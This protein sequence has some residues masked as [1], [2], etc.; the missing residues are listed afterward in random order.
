[1]WLNRCKFIELPKI[2]D[3]RGNLTFIENNGY[4]PFEIQRV[5]YIY[6]VP[7]GSDRG[8]HAHRQLQQL[9][10]ALSGSFDLELDDGF[11]KKTISLNR[12][13]CG[14]YICPMIWR[15]ITNFSSGA[16]CLVLASECFQEADYFRHY[17]EF[18]NES[19][20]IANEIASAVS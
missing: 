9:V 8:G 4:L 3:S 14:L 17:G 5:Y 18:L 13:H 15:T 2:I 10:I 12:A 7:G 16:V 19:Q 6:D 11:E 1:M 20:R